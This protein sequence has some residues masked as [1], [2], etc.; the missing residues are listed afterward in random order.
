MRTLLGLGWSDAYF[1][2]ALDVD[3]YSHMMFLR[4]Q[5]WQGLA[6]LHLSLEAAQALQAWSTR[7][8]ERD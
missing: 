5:R 3:S 1:G 4:M 8:P 2:V 7:L 6:S